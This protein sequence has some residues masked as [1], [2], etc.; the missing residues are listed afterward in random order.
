MKT[1]T[2]HTEAVMFIEDGCI[3]LTETIDGHPSTEGIGTIQVN[4]DR[5][6]VIDALVHRYNTQPDLLA[7][8]KEILGWADRAGCSEAFQRPARA[9]I[10]KAEGGAD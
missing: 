10:A 5:E 1:E 3:H 6:V 8:L 9:A 7:A 2:K 4:D